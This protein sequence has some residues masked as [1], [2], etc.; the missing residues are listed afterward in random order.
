[1][2]NKGMAISGI[3]YSIL[4]LII[5]LI[6]G[7]LS[8]LGNARLSFNKF[9]GDIINNLMNDN[10]KT[11]GFQSYKENILN[12]ADPVL[13]ANMIPVNIEKNGTVKKADVSQRWYSYHTK[14][15][16][17]AVLVKA[18]KLDKYQNSDISTIINEND[19]IAYFV[20][21][22]RFKYKNSNS[23]LNTYNSF[24]I[25]FENKQILKS[26]GDG[27]TTYYTH[28]AFTFGE[29]ELNGI[30]VGKFES[31]G[32]VKTTTILPNK[33]PQI[34]D[35]LTEIQSNIYK[36]EDNTD[37]SDTHIMKNS[38]WGAMAYLTS[39]EFGLNDNVQI[40]NSKE[41]L[42]GCSSSK[43][44]FSSNDHCQ[45]KYGENNIFYHSTTGNINGIFDTSGGALD[46]VMGNYNQEKDKL[47]FDIFP[48]YKYYDIYKSNYSSNNSKG[49]ATYE[50]ASWNNNF[51]EELSSSKPWIGRGGRYNSENEAGIFSVS[52][53]SFVSE[54]LKET[55]PNGYRIVLTEKDKT[56]YKESLLNGALPELDKGMI[57]I[58]IDDDGTASKADLSNKW[59]SY[60]DK[61]WANA[62]IVKESSRNEYINADH[63]TIIE[64]DDILGYFVWIPRYKY[65]IPTGGTPIPSTIDVIF[66]NNKIAKS[67]GNAT[68]QYFTPPGF[69]FGDEEL[70]GMWISKFEIT[71]LSTAPTILPNTK[72]LN[73]QTISEEF[74]TAKL[75]NNYGITNDA[76]MIKNSE[77]ATI[78]YLSH[79]IYGINKEIRLNNNSQLLT[80]CGASTE[81][82]ASTGQCQI[83]YGSAEEYPQSTT[84]NINGIFDMSG[85]SYDRVM[86]NF[87]NTIANSG[88]S[89]MPE[90][91]YY[92]YYESTTYAPENSKGHATYETTNWYSDD[93]E[94][95][96]LESPWVARGNHYIAEAATGIF[97]TYFTTGVSYNA[98]GFKIVIS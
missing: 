3:L 17:N 42:T 63:G 4:V 62:V 50:T 39:S 16:A 49:H 86:A 69:T 11:G 53:N 97:Q 8:I 33:K 89:S 12:G 91:K 29:K 85:G 21:I 98:G 51:Y 1:M 2:N 58:T 30:W 96:S 13:D 87:N 84:G 31:T 54:E 41:L 28:P 24:D 83:Q 19:I 61:L 67:K 94:N 95:L 75:F 81:N 38:E 23:G 56:T 34:I 68:T 9:K 44:D 18:N 72:A 45:Y 74:E 20:W 80:G 82:A 46:I 22:P 92:D 10:D 77:W 14:E 76:H 93:L 43:Y 7:I 66:E 40:N 27:E 59:Y 26:N 79:S 55:Q 15:W 73:N 88:F 6:F 52:S 71:G 70:N 47:G 78:A 57:P 32:T 37:Y 36:F 90:S 64:Q 48:S 35:S 60:E 65:K 25:V 5:A